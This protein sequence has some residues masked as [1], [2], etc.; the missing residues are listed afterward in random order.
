MGWFHEGQPGHEGFF[1]GFVSREGTT[2]LWRELGY[3]DQGTHTLERL[4]VGCDCGWRSTHF[5][6][7]A[8][9]R[10]SWAP[11]SVILEG[12][13][14]AVEQAEA[15]ARLLWRVHVEQLRDVPIVDAKAPLV[16]LARHSRIPVYRGERMCVPEVPGGA[17]RDPFSC[18]CDAWYAP[19]EARRRHAPGCPAGMGG[20]KR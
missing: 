17:S 5:P 3:P 4:A 7:P 20:A 19:P 1:V 10:A 16:L 15:E 6:P 11:S 12:S 9:V 13:T 18:S 8:I 2:S 14:L